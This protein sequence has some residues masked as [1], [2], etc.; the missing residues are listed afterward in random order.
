MCNWVRFI[1]VDVDVEQ[2]REMCWIVCD[3]NKKLRNV[4]NDKNAQWFEKKEEERISAERYDELMDKWEC[5][6]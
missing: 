1:D 3:M 4:K 5:N 6:I 2:G